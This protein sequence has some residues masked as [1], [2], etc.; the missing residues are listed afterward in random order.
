VGLMSSSKLATNRMLRS[1]G[2]Q[3]VSTR[4]LDRLNAKDPLEHVFKDGVEANRARMKPRDG[5]PA[6]T[7]SCV[8]LDTL[9]RESLALRKQSDELVALRR[10]VAILS[11]G[12]RAV[13]QASARPDEAR[14]GILHANLRL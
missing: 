14:E 13:R 10:E 11:G 12:Q 5:D 9:L 4:T 6:E 2:V 7:V 8:F 3:L 1:I